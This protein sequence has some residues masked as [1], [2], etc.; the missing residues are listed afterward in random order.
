[1]CKALQARSR[2][3]LNLTNERK[4]MST[5]TLRKRI[6]LAAVTALGSGLLSVVA[7]PSA[8]SA[9]TIADKF[10]IAIGNSSTGSNVVTAGG[11]D[12]TLDKSIGFVAVTS[13]AS[14]NQEAVAGTAVTVKAGA[15]GTAN[16]L[17]GSK[18]VLGVTGG[19]ITDR[20]AMT[21]VNGTL[22]NR[23]S[24]TIASTVV[25]I[26]ANVLEVT[27]AGHGL[28]VG[29]RVTVDSTTAGF[30][31]AT[32]VAITAVTTNTFTV[33]LTGADAGPTTEAGVITL[34]ES[35]PFNGTNTAVYRSNGK[36]PSLA[37]V[38]TVNPGATSMSCSAWKGSTVTA[39]TPTVG[40]LIGQW[41]FTVVSAS[42]SGV[43]S[44]ADSTVYIGANAAKGTACSAGAAP[45]FD[46]F[47][48]NDNG[49]VACIYVDLNDAYGTAIGSTGSLQAS[50]T[51]G[52]LV[53]VGG[54]A[55]DAYTASLSF[56]SDTYATGGSWIS[57][58][59]PVS[60][61][62]GS[63]TV[64]V[65][66]QGVV[67]GTKTIN[68]NGIAS[69]IELVSAESVSIFSSSG[70]SNSTVPA[71]SKLGIVYRIKDAAGNNI[72]NASTPTI[73]DA[74][75][76]MIS[77]T[78]DATATATENVVQ[79]VSAGKG[80]STMYI[81]SSSV[82]GA[83]TYKLSITNSAGTV[84]KSPVYNAT[85]VG[86]VATFTASWDKAVYTSGEIATLTIKGLDSS[87][88]T[89]ADGLPLGTGTVIS[90]NSD[91]FAHLTSSCETTAT[92]TPATTAVYLGG[93]KTCKF[94][95]KNTP[96]SYSYSVKVASS[97]GQAEVVGTAAVVASTATTSNADV[98]KA[99]VSLIA[100]INKQIAALQKALLRR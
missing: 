19:A 71:G 59:Q 26:A 41:V 97:T 100:S 85:V 12:T 83:G 34:A 75:G 25:E 91:G 86:S 24:A 62:A 52:S 2:K 32:A 95:V 53:E 11:G 64:T 74:T 48:R 30:D 16:V 89:A 68:W 50:A 65:T 93:E 27:S 22:S 63:T 98:L 69:T 46:N 61:T 3:F 47:A 80:R 78:L 73:A 45:T 14:G 20:V 5:K 99:I 56:D 81:G 51:G 87:G 4:N 13:A 70:S 82:T 49:R 66:Y 79:T 6:A 1:M 57:V 94:A 84:I 31:V 44:A 28:L 39:S 72:A 42:V 35:A 33:P 23:S 9:V 37:V 40:T 58:L 96:G 54:A 77:A 8:N 38:A 17:A 55:A 21:C 76:S 18:L 10:S 15:V 7:V 67:L 43:V 29:D 60:N 92:T 36:N 90:V 88:R